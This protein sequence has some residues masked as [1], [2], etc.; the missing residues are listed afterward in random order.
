MKAIQ[1]LVNSQ[2]PD[3]LKDYER[4]MDKKSIAAL[5]ADVARKYPERYEEIAKTIAD[6]G[7]KASYLQGETLTLKDT[8]PV[9]DRQKLF[10]KMDN[11]IATA[12]RTL[13]DADYKRARTQIWSKYA[14]EITGT[15]QR[16]SLAQGSNLAN[17]VISGARGNASQ[18]RMMISTPALYTDSKDE[19][20]PLFVRRSFGDGLRPAEY[21]A[22]TYGARKSV[23]S[24]K[25]ATAKGGDLAKQ[26]VQVNTPLIVTTSDCGVRNGVDLEIDDSSLRGRVLAEDY[27]PIKAGTILDRQALNELK[28]KQGLKKLIVRSA[29]TCDAEEGICAKCVGVNPKGQFPELGDTIG[30]TAAQS[31]GEPITQGA[32][33]TKHSGGAAQGAKRTYAGF[34]VIN[35]FVQAPEEFPDRAVVAKQDGVVSKIEE[36][37]QGGYFVTVGSEQ[38]Y[39]PPGYPVLVKRGDNL[40]AGDQLSEGLV[41]ASDIVE[42]RGIG[43]GRRYY[44][45]RLKQILDDSGMTADRRNTEIIARSA[46]NH[47]QMEDADDDAPFLPDDVISYQQMSRHYTPPEDT[48]RENVQKAVGKYLQQPMLHYTIGTRI[49]PSVAKRLEEVGK[50]EVYASA[51]APN[52]APNMV[53]LR[54]A[55]HANRDWMA[56]MH[57]SYLKKNLAES[58]IRGDDTNVRENVH[59][60]P[61]LAIGEG[62]AQNITE[63]GKF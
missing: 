48:T 28:N 5:L 6:L 7:R 24:T 63:T 21:L 4:P 14:D 32:L 12:K 49:T 20:V 36:A 57:T 16:E 2:L 13:N 47:L 45:D 22:S 54:T 44:S 8:Q 51:K 37:P 62:F 53:R 26:L 29:L 41:D 34:D 17:T 55:S 3:D 15:T 25:R 11:E 18:L 40:E 9:F 38:H 59:F 30:I 1:L 56:G 46:L 50:R 23:L 27:G 60:A 42:L 10:D 52:F 43:E 61:R 39:V 33:N 35:R 58:A 19:I 31:V